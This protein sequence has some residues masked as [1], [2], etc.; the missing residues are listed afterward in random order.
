MNLIFK[1]ASHRGDSQAALFLHLWQVRSWRAP[2]AAVC[3]VPC[4]S[5]DQGLPRSIGLWRTKGKEKNEPL[6]QAVHWKWSTTKQKWFLCVKI[7]RKSS[8]SLY[9]RKYSSFKISQWPVYPESSAALG[10]WGCS[11]LV[12]GGPGKNWPAPLYLFMPHRNVVGWIKDWWLGLRNCYVQWE[13]GRFIN[14]CTELSEYRDHLLFL[15]CDVLSGRS[16]CSRGPKFR[17][18]SLPF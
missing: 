6:S 12:R 8:L 10:S 16:V 3:W 13:Q 17:Q 14:K 9:K 5:K 11:N 2:G 18:G 7:T 15:G 4:T 1:W